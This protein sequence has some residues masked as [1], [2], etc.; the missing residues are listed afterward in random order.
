[1]SQAVVDALSLG[2]IYALFTL[3]LSLVWGVLG[4]LNLAHGSVFAASAY[5]A[6]EFA[7]KTGTTLWLVLPFAMLAGGLIALLL[8]LLVFAPIRRTAGDSHH[9]SHAT[10]IGGIGASAILVTYVQNKLGVEAVRLPRE[11]LDLHT[12]FVAGVH[13][14]NLTIVIIATA[15]ILGTVTGLWVK[16][17]HQGR[18]L[19]SLAYD[20]EATALLGVPA[21]MLAAVAMFVGGALAGGA[22]VLL[23]LNFSVVSP[24]M[25]EGLMLKAFAVVIIGGVGNIFGAMVGGYLLALAEVFAVYFGHGDLR[26]AIA[27]AVVV[28]VLMV[29]PGG[30]FQRGRLE[31]V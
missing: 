8:E 20:R 18:A 12:Y 23:A 7:T 10:L 1:M 4:L 25:G 30:L 21:S 28:A 6:Y 27:F 26:D 24:V 15:L 3:G 5:A 11:V 13:F 14:T 16:W 22:G 29:R 17:S 9:A 31:R 19:R 2:S